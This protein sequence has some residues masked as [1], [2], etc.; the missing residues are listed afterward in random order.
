MTEE[1]L[2]FIQFALRQNEAIDSHLRI[3]VLINPKFSTTPPVILGL[4]LFPMSLSAAVANT[5]TMAWMP[6]F[7]FKK[8]RS[9]ELCRRKACIYP[10]DSLPT[11]PMIL[12]RHQPPLNPLLMD[13]PWLLTIFP[14]CSTDHRQK[15]SGFSSDQWNRI[16]INFRLFSPIEVRS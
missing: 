5:T 15:P 14:F 3:P 2:M 8:S 4:C 6:F 10:Q 9:D 16:S 13:N 1:T 11:H 7:P 12:Q